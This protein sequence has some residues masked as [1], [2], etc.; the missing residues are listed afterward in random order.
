MYVEA[1]IVAESR[2]AMALP[3]EAVVNLE[4]RYFIL[5]KKTAEGPDMSFEKREVQVGRLDNGFYEILNAGEIG[6]N[7]TLL[8]RGAFNLIQEE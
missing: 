3:E 1:E 2:P 8:T 7:A 5:V 6:A 4:T